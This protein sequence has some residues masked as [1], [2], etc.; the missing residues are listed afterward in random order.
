M[1]AIT[2][3]PRSVLER[4]LRDYDVG[5]LIGFKP[6]SEGIEN[7]NYF[8]RTA[9]KT[10]ASDEAEEF[11][12][13][14]IEAEDPSDRDRDLMIRILDTCYESGLPVAPV[15]RTRSGTRATEIFSKPVY[16]SPVLE[17]IHTAVPVRD[18]CEAVGRFLARMHLVTESLECDEYPYIRDAAWLEQSRELVFRHLGFTEREMLRDAVAQVTSMLA[19]NDITH[20]PQG[21]IHGDLFRDNALFNRYGLNGVVDFHHASKGYWIYD[22]AVTL[23][24]WCRDGASLDVERSLAFMQEYNAI[25]AFAPGELWFLPIFLLYGAVAFWLS[26][27]LVAVRE[28][29]PSAYP[30]KDPAEFA[31]VVAHHLRTPFRVDPHLFD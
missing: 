20:L 30:V 8:L 24:D 4:V 6:A 3:L 16:L 27:L 11:V 5:P 29:L 21:V 25:R 1:A 7:T 22:V 23:N 14:L 19:R 31:E 10:E 28:D 18:Q 2:D 13:T 26:R 9:G 17:G 12:I 15:I